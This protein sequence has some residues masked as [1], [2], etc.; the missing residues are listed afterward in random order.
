MTPVTFLPLGIWRCSKQCRMPIKKSFFF[1]SVRGESLHCYA[2][3]LTVTV[4]MRILDL[5]QHNMIQNG[6]Y[7]PRGICEKMQVFNL[8]CEL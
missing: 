8:L 3:I 1:N 4:K 2:S 6:S 7:V 5:P